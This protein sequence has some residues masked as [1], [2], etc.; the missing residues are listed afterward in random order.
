MPLCAFL[1]RGEAVVA[2]SSPG[3][4]VLSL[5]PVRECYTKWDAAALFRAIVT[6]GCG[7]AAMA[8]LPGPE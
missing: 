8:D 3:K 2:G 6:L 5:L 1:Q 7:V 4:P